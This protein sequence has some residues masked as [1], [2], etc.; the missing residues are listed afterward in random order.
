MI[1]VV[2][3]DYNFPI[4]Q[5]IWTFCHHSPHF[6]FHLHSATASCSDMFW[7]CDVYI[8]VQKKLNPVLSSCSL[9]TFVL[10]WKDD[11][12]YFVWDQ[13]QLFNCA[14]E[15]YF[16]Y[17]SLTEQH[18]TS[19]IVSLFESGTFLVQCLFYWYQRSENSAISDHKVLFNINTVK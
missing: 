13:P 18:H 9:C 15:Y 10:W 19:V 6:R 3:V 16:R 1:I 17:S 5:L 14:D 4:L 11:I 8:F 7:V 2:S 12:C